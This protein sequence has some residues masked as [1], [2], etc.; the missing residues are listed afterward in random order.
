MVMTQT[1]I[2]SDID[3]WSVAIALFT[4]VCVVLSWAALN[5]EIYLV[6]IRIL[7]RESVPAYVPELIEQLL[8]LCPIPVLILFRRIV[9][10]MGP[11]EMSPV[12]TASYDRLTL[13]KGVSPIE[14]IRD[15]LRRRIGMHAHS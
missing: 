11:I 10:I 5:L 14:I 4:M 6:A 9:R 15:P 1:E 3:R 8:W 12:R 7:H 2:E 13:D